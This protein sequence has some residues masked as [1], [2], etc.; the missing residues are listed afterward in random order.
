MGLDT[1][2]YWLTD[3]QSQY[4]FDFHFDPVSWK[5]ACEEKTRRLVWND[6]QPAS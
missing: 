4:D 1:K 5:S 3:R 2:T 6:R